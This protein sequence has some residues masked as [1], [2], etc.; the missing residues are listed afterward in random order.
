MNIQ[1][2]HEFQQLV[3]NMAV[4]QLSFDGINSWNCGVGTVVLEIKKL[5]QEWNIQYP[6]F[7]SKIYLLTPDYV[8]TLS[9]Y[10]NDI[11]K[12]N[13]ADCKNSGGDVLLLPTQKNNLFFGNP[14]QWKELCETGVNECAKI[15]NQNPF[16]IVLAHCSAFAQIP[17]YL[18]NLEQKKKIHQPYRVLW[19]PHSTSWSYDGHINSSPVWPERHDWE[20]TAFQKAPEYNYHIGYLCD[21]FKK[22][23]T[24]TPFNVS[25]PSLFHFRTGIIGDKYLQQYSLDEI[26]NELIKRSIPTDKQILFSIGNSSYLKG[27]DIVLE[28][29]KYL[30]PN[31]PDLHLVL[32]APR[33][34]HGPEF[35]ELLKKRN[36]EENINATIIETFDSNLASYIYQWPLT[37]LVLLLS[38]EDIQPLTV[39]EARTNPKNCVVLVSNI[40]GLG[41]QVSDGKD[42]FICNIDGLPKTITKPLPFCSTLKEI[43]KKAEYVL[44]LKGELRDKI[45]QNGKKLIAEKYNMRTSLK[46]NLLRLINKSLV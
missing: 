14:E 5:L 40:D 17:I 30:K 43:V 19:I 22:Q 6:G 45:I 46:D 36:Q 44:N 8:N 11:L 33:C 31:F 41:S 23:I 4:V 27:H 1:K 24:N 2:G 32:L 37:N 7:H 42:G 9:E 29:Y 3:N 21:T 28:I 20:L 15:I 35:L 12:S 10:S 34:G 39:M 26:T 25:E 18:K 13:M 16:T 38:R